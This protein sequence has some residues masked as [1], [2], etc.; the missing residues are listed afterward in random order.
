MGLVQ[1]AKATKSVIETAPEVKEPWNLV[2]FIVNIILPG[3]NNT[4]GMITRYWYHHW[5]SNWKV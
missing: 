3:I 5:S 1:K 2:L 4:L